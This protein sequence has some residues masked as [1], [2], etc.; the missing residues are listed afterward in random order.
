MV[1]KLFTL[2]SYILRNI[3]IAD[4]I[5]M[6]E[7]T[8]PCY[9]WFDTL[10]KHLSLFLPIVFVIHLC[11]MRFCNSSRVFVDGVS[12]IITRIKSRKSSV[13]PDI[14]TI[15]IFIDNLANYW[16]I[17]ESSFSLQF[18]IFQDH[19]IILMFLLFS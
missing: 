18:L 17:W 16:I 5:D 9:Y 10:I 14:I 7:S 8:R 12:S 6:L 15:S 13:G 11:F 19:F 3:I 2:W 4:R 1:K